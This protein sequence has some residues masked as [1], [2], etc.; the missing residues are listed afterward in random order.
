MLEDKKAE[1][2]S[3]R[4]YNLLK[5]NELQV[6]FDTLVT[7][8]LSGDNNSPSSL[9]HIGPSLNYIRPC[10]A[11]KATCHHDIGTYFKRH[12]GFII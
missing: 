5:S 1:V 10:S 9:N 4:L 6:G 7:S 3:N 11:Y 8:W 12:L 2:P